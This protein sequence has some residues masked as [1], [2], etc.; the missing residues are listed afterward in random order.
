MH[1]IL[2]YPAGL[3]LVPQRHIE[4]M[5]QLTEDEAIELGSMLREVSA[6]LKEMTGCVKT[7]IIQFAEHPDHPHAH[8]HIVPRMPDL[9][10]EFRGPRIF[11]LLGR[12]EAER[13]PEEDRDKLARMRR[14]LR[15]KRVS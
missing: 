1:T 11:A 15:C 12:D 10:A 13:V 5:D 8:F 4:S 9:P 2:R 7:Y 14:R 6:A 3:V